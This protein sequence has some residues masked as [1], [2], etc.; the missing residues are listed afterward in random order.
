MPL[1][2]EVLGLYS[3]HHPKSKFR[4]THCHVQ[5][6]ELSDFSIREWPMRDIAELE[7][8]GALADT[9]ETE[10]AR[11]TFAGSNFGIKVC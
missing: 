4:C 2:E 6:H 10:A 1:L 11:K 3:V 9:R 7:R 8:C 5:R